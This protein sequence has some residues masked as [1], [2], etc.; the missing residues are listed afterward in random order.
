MNSAAIVDRQ[1]RFENL[2]ELL[3]PAEVCYVQTCKDFS[4][5]EEELNGKNKEIQAP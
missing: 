3:T 2:P 4:W 5:F 1:T